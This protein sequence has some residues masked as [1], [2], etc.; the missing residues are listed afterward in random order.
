MS[1]VKT[2]AE[3]ITAMAEKINA[4]AEKHD[5]DNTKIVNT[6]DEHAAG[7]VRMYHDFVRDITDVRE[8]VDQWS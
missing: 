2:M 7:L 8:Q 3:K 1:V 5:V 4:M 6:I